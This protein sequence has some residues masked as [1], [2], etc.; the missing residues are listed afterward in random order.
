MEKR[1]EERGHGGVKLM[2]N[3]WGGGECNSSGEKEGNGGRH[4]GSRCTT[5]R[6]LPGRGGGRGESVRVG[7]GSVRT[8]CQPGEG[9]WKVK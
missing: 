7:V 4:M 2:E 9:L 1:G 8:K 6:L 3:C 5:K